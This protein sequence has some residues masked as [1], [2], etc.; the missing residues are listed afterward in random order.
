MD[1]LTV[2]KQQNLI[3]VEEAKEK[4]SLTKVYTKDDFSVVNRF[5]SKLKYLFY[6]DIKLLYLF[7]YK[8]G[9]YLS[10][11]YTNNVNQSCVIP[12]ARDPSYKK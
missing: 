5:E 7:G 12:K 11:I 4:T 2:A 10:K 9:V 6:T 3:V 1:T 8:A